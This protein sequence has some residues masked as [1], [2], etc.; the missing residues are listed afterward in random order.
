MPPTA[1]QLWI[2]PSP[3]R[4]STVTTR[5]VPAVGIFFR[6]VTWRVITTQTTHRD[7]TL[8]VSSLPHMSDRALEAWMTSS[9]GPFL[10]INAG[11]PFAGVVTISVASEGADQ[12]LVKATWEHDRD[13]RSTSKTVT[14]YE[15]ARTLAHEWVDQ[16]GAGR[17]PPR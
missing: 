3:G 8:T 12:L 10:T 13:P 1:A 17:E 11:G 7:H 4:P 14:G 15:R 16:L 9:A 5:F 2:L 6:A